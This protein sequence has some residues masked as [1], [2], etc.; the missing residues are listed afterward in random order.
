MATDF[1]MPKLGLTM[2][3]GTI[4]AWLVPD[5]SEVTAGTA[6]EKGQVLMVL[7]APGASGDGAG[8]P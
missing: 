1:L 2:E 5:G 8:L 6:V 7:T 4:T 3:E